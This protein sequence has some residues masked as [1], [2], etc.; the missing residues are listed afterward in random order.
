[1]GPAWLVL[2]VALIGG[3]ILVHAAAMLQRDG[4]RL[5]TPIG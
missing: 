4:E 3:L 5:R 2:V 1:M